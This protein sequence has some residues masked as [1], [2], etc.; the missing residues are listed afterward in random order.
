MTA[1]GST[2]NTYISNNA[3]QNRNKTCLKAW[4]PCLKIWNSVPFK[5]SSFS[6]SKSPTRV[7][8]QLPKKTDNETAPP[9][10]CV[11]SAKESNLQTIVGTIELQ[12]Q[13]LD[14]KVEHE[15]GI[16]Q[17]CLTEAWIWSSPNMW[18]QSHLQCL[19][20]LLGIDELQVQ[21]VLMKTQGQPGQPS[22][23]V[24]QLSF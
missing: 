14:S 10:S 13:G 3:L 12:S 20:K 24:K 1:T 11:I 2:P 6:S 18:P 15:A 22:K 8:L 7:F 23:S 4:L 21:A 9:K 17:A 5:K 16:D 19:S